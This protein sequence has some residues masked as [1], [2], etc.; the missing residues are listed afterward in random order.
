MPYIKQEQREQLD[1]YI[2]SLLKVLP[3]EQFAGNMNYIITRLADGMLQRQKN[4]ACI[5][6]VIGALECAKLELY[7]RVAGPYEDLKI[8][9][10]G[11]VYGA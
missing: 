2:D 3:D 6:E 5:N 10:N 11:D 4:Y 8:T 1:S 9:E 7:R